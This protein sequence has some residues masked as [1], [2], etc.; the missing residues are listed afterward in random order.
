[1]ALH[2]NS[3][4]NALELPQSCTKPYVQRHELDATL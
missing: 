3:I 1:M 2:S 4:A